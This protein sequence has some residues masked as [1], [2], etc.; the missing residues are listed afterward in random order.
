[1]VN[2]ENLDVI[3]IG[4]S[5]V[6]FSSDI[7]LSDAECLHKSYGGDALAAA[8][9]VQR[10]GG[11]AGFITRVGEDCFK[12]FLIKNWQDEGLDISHVRTAPD[13]NG[14]YITAR[15]ASGVKEVVYHRKKTASAKLSIDDIEPDYLA[16]TKIVYSSGLTQALS[17][18]AKEAVAYAFRTAK[19][20]GIQ[21]AYDPN[22]YPDILNVQ[23]AK[24]NFDEVIT[25]VDIAFMSTRRDTVD[26]LELDSPEHVIK[27]LWDFGV[28]IVVV[29]SA[30][31]GGYYTGYNGNIAFTEFYIKDIA[32]TT[33]TG[34]VFNGAFLYAITHSLTPF[35]AA[36]LASITAGLQVERLGAIKSI[37]RADEVYPIFEKSGEQ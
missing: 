34:D 35:E 33:C 13:T 2:L 37:P 14:I 6:E 7:K 1:M 26:I 28:G 24:E 19:E 31:E 4:E 15:P 3:A 8:V 12:D 5:L 27:K 9:T 21:T 30:A 18:S 22:F 16:S 17:I 11:H 20:L 29:K 32:D 10:L 25:N 36:K 23:E